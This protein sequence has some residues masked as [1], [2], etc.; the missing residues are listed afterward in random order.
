MR[1]IYAF[2]KLQVWHDARA[3]VKEIYKLTESLPAEEKYGLSSQMRRSGVSVISNI[4]EGSGR[5]SKK[6]QAHFY[7][8]AFSSLIEL[9]NQLIISHDLTFISDEDLHVL[10]KEIEKISNKINALRKSCFNQ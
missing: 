1:Y 8:M 7:Q 9:L 6:D 4:A 3:L 2:E 10:R 5:S